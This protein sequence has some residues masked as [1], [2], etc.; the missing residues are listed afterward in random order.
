MAMRRD[1]KVT[2]VSEDMPCVA[3]MFSS[4]VLER[5]ENH[6]DTHLLVSRGKWLNGDYYLHYYMSAFT[7]KPCRK[8]VPAAAWL[9]LDCNNTT[10]RT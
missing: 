3:S 7:V 5:E 4:S 1:R 9:N 6:T 10:D 2:A 8:R